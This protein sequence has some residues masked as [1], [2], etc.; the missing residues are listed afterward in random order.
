[1]A[2]QIKKNYSS[3][4]KDFLTYGINAKEKT[5][6]VHLRPL[7][8]ESEESAGNF[9]EAHFNLVKPVKYRWN[10]ERFVK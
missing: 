9:S 7:D 1:M 6:E 2:A 5:L 10:G 3:R 8:Y 4:P